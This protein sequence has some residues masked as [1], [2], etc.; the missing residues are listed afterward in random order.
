MPQLANA[1]L[2]SSGVPHAW[3]G[4]SA[5]KALGIHAPAADRL[6]VLPPGAPD[7][8]GALDPARSGEGAS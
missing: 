4:S 1:P 3:T 8:P 7:R 6:T 2:L 5:T